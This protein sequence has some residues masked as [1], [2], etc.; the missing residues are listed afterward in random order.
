[1]F[2]P[3][4]VRFLLRS[5]VLP[6]LVLVTFRVRIA[7]LPP[8]LIVVVVE[9]ALALTFVRERTWSFPEAAMSE[10]VNNAPV[11]ALISMRFVFISLFWF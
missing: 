11:T 3:V 10:P 1:M 2:R 9:G 7:V 5:A 8:E 4:E 6:S